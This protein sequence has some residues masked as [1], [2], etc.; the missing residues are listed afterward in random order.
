LTLLVYQTSDGDFA[1]RA[2]EALQDAQIPCRREG[3]HTAGDGSYLGRAG[4]VASIYI[5]R[6]SDFR[7][8]NEI[9]VR[10]GAATEKPIPRFVTA[11]G[12]PVALLLLL[13]VIAA[14][15]VAIF[16]SK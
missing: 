7:A 10:L 4:G 11:W 5:D 1:D 13:V 14:I 16:G 12:V 2:I 6:D 3:P 8:A 9:L 15:L